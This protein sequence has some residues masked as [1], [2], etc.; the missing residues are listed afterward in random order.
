[1]GLEAVVEFG[2]AEN[3][4]NIARD[5]ADTGER[6]SGEDIFRGRIGGVYFTIKYLGGHESSASSIMGFG[7]CVEVCNV[8]KQHIITRCDVPRDYQGT[9]AEFVQEIYEVLEK[10]P[11]K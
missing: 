9:K 3:L 4:F 7:G 2:K 10:D 8:D 11:R 5:I 1:M 6:S